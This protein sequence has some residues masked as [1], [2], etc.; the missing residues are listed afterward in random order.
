[1]SADFLDT[2]CIDVMT[3]EELLLE[4]TSFEKQLL[5]TCGLSESSRVQHWIDL[6]ALE[7]TLEELSRALLDR[8]SRKLKRGAL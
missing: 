7:T 5:V 3:K 8:F 2:L 6:Q 4:R 1:M